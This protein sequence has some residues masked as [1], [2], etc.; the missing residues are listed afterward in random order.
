M[1]RPVGGHARHGNHA[2]RGRRA[3]TIGRSRVAAMRGARAR[4]AGAALQKANETIQ[5]NEL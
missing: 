1:A 2:A 4:S 5:Q 3:G